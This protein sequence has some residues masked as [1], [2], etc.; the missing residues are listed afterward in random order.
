M[1]E[2]IEALP[3]GSYVAISHFFDLETPEFSEFARKLEQVFLHSPLG[4]GW[5]RTRA[6][7]QG[8]FPGLEPSGRPAPGS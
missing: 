8:M 1:T 6:E 5:F 2:D 4:S 3:S 7:I